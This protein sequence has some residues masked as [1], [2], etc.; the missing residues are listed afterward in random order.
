MVAKST[1]KTAQN[2]SGDI[3][4]ALIFEVGGLAVIT[5]VAGLSD[6]VANLMVLLIFGVFLLWLMNNFD[7]VNGLLNSVNRI[8]KAVA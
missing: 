2:Q 7:K 8:E 4:L 6:Q 1:A 3:L 5:A